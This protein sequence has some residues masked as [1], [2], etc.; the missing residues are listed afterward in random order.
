MK[1]VER[2]PFAGDAHWGKGGRFVLIDGRRV[3]AESV[4][5]PG[6]LESPVAAPSAPANSSQKPTRRKRG[7]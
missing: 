3:P 5:Q 1:H 7:Q 2:L 4:Q 6:S